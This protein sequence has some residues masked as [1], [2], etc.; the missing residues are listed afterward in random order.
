[1]IFGNKNNKSSGANLLL[2]S[3]DSLAA[4]KEE[5]Q[6]KD[7]GDSVDRFIDQYERAS[8]MMRARTPFWVNCVFMPVIVC[9]SLGAMYVLIF[10]KT[11]DSSLKDKALTGL[12]GRPWKTQAIC[13]TMVL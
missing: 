7:S 8:N 1:M 9:A 3:V 11:A 12:L 2:Q 4:V 10:D 13:G 6:Q 5:L